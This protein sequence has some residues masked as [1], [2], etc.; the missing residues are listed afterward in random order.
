MSNKE[1]LRGLIGRSARNTGPQQSTIQDAQVI[2]LP[3]L[4]GPPS[5]RELIRL[6]TVEELS[7]FPDGT[8]V[9]WHVP[10][11]PGYERQAGVLDSY[12]GVRDIRPISVLPYESNTD[13]YHVRP[14]VWV[15]TFPD[16]P[17]NDDDT[18]NDSDSSVDDAT[19]EEVRDRLAA[20]TSAEAMGINPET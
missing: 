8:V 15:L 4:P 2:R 18:Q 13:L 14:P 11:G 12:E 3:N 7:A 1:S 20:H 6:D 17:A 9:I 16:D 19:P 5:P 10:D